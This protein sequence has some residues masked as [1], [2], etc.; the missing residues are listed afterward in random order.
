MFKP[1]RQQAKNKSVNRK[2]AAPTHTK[3]NSLMK[4][5]SRLN[6]ATINELVKATGWQPHSVRAF[7]AD[8][9]HNKAATVLVIPKN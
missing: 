5:L 6:G 2:S 9:A 7:L 1:T 4:L 8:H 3:T